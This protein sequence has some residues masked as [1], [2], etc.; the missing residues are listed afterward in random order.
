VSGRGA[1]R[2][3]PGPSS[4]LWN[5]STT[6]SGFAGGTPKDHAAGRTAPCLEV[7]IGGKFVDETGEFALDF[8]AA[9]QP[10]L[11]QKVGIWT[12]GELSWWF[13]G[14]TICVLVAAGLDPHRA[15]GFGFL[16]VRGGVAGVQDSLRMVPAGAAL[17]GG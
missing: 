6:Q 2:A 16:P 11:R 9:A 17:I 12:S 4:T 7:L 1:N 8:L 3:R 15:S 5:C 14:Q 13:P 10:L